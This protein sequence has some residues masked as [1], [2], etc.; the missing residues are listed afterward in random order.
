MMLLVGVSAMPIKLRSVGK[1][2]HTFPDKTTENYDAIFYDAEF[3][4][5][6]GEIII[7]F[8]YRE[9]YGRS[10]RR[11]VVFIDKHPEAEFVGSDDYDKT[12]HLVALIRRRD[13]KYMRINGIHPIYA[14]FNIVN[15]SSQI[16]KNLG[17]REGFAALLVTEDDHKTMILHAIIQSTWRRARKEQGEL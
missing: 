5:W 3:G 15:H 9:A 16:S 1:Y 2:T 8:T 13:G 17:G 14:G 6:R 4:D 10:R 11:V 7:G 12:G